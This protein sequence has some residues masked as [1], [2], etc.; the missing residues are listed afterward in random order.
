MSLLDDGIDRTFAYAQMLKAARF[1]LASNLAE[2]SF[3]TYIHFAPT[4]ST[5]TDTKV[6]SDTIVQ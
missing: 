1:C 5:R 2:T 4:I 3:E 6:S